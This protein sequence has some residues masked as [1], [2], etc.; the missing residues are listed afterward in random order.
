MT[1]TPLIRRVAADIVGRIRDQQ[2]QPGT[3][4]VERDLAEHLRVSRSPV[5]QWVGHAGECGP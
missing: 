5:S 4:L 3:R 2:L 1:P